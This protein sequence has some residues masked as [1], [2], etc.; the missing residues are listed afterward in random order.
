VE[1]SQKKAIFLAISSIGKNCHGIIYLKYLR[2]FRKRFSRDKRRHKRGCKRVIEERKRRPLDFVVIKI[3]S[4]K[5]S[6]I[7]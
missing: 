1:D 7:Y 6:A 3:L 5:M 2:R 4:Q